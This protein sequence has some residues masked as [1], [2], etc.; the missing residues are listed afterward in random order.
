MRRVAP[1][2]LVLA[3]T[4]AL[5]ACGGGTSPTAS[6]TPKLA[7]ATF[8]RSAGA[9]TSTAPSEHMTISSKLDASGMQATLKGS[10]DFSN[11]A[12]QGSLHASFSAGGMSGSMDTILHSTTLYVSSPLLGS[13]LPSGKTWVKLDL[14]KLGRAN[15]LDLSALMA[16][17]PSD[18]LAQLSAVG[19][20]TTVGPETIDGVETTHY[21]VQIDPS[22]LPDAAKIQ[23][24]AQ[25]K[26]GDVNIWVGNADGYVRRIS[27]SVSFSAGGASGTMSVTMG[28]SDFGE[29]VHVTPPPAGETFDGTDLGLQGLGT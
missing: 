22:K 16:Q 15:G 26:Y 3:A 2:S 23:A 24:L 27:T 19:S 13:F 9:K 1:V 28:F 21:R 11:T 12:K 7:P 17:T 18:A 14:Q 20:A 10:G 5:A 4:L 6:P 29:T 25:P 8:V